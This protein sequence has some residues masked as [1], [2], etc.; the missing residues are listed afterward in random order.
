MPASPTHVFDILAVDG[1]AR[2]PDIE[3]V[4]GARLTELTGYE[5]SKSGADPYADMMNQWQHLLPAYG[6]VVPSVGISIRFSAGTPVID[7][8]DAAGSNIVAADFTITDNGDGNTSIQW[9]STLLPS[10]GRKP[11]L[12]LHG[13]GI[14]SGGAILTLNATP[15]VHDVTVITTVSASGAAANVPFTVDIH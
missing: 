2:R 6:R 5:P 14:H 8:L 10:P 4:G 9:A 7:V 13:V 15:G 3:D 1:G 12:T 11:H